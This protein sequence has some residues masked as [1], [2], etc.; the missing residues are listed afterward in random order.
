MNSYIIFIIPSSCVVNLRKRW[1]L[2]AIHAL[3]SLFGTDFRFSPEGVRH[4]DV[5]NNLNI[6]N[7]NLLRP[8]LIRGSCCD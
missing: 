7:Y 2:R 4:M 8:D 3:K 1:L 5:L 6:L